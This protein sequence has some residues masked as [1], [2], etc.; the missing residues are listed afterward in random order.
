M[1]TETGQAV[2]ALWSQPLARWDAVRVRQA[3]VFLA[4]QA[5]AALLGLLLA[6]SDFAG[7]AFAAAAPFAIA[8][9]AAAHVKYLGM[10]ILGMAAGCLLLLDWPGNITAMAA[11]A[12]AGLGNLGLRRLGAR[13]SVAVPLNAFGCALA[14]AVVA[15]LAEPPAALIPWIF[16]ICGAVLAGC[17]G[18]FIVA[19]Q[20]VRRQ[21]GQL[22]VGRRECAALLL[23]GGM[24]LAALG[25]FSLGMFRPANVLGVLFV[26]AAA[27]CWREPGG[28]VAGVCAGAAL[29]LAGGDASLTA[30]FAFGGLLAGAFSLHRTRQEEPG[31]SNAMLTMPVAGGF[32]LVCVFFVML[33]GTAQHDPSSAVVFAI[34]S[35]VAIMAF[36]LVPAKLW[37]RLRAKLAAPGEE[38]SSGGDG[39]AG[40]RLSRASGALR[41]VGEFVG[42]VAQ[43]LEKIQTPLEPRI[44]AAAE[45]ALCKGCVEYP[46]CYDDHA[47]ESR[48]F[49]QQAVKRLKQGSALQP[50]EFAALR[51]DC[52]LTLPCRHLEQFRGV[53]LR[54]FDMYAAQQ[55]NADANAHLRKAAAAQFDA[56]SELIDEVG[57]QLT[58]QR[59]FE[60]EAAQSAVQVLEDHGYKTKTVSCVRG[61]ENTARLT[62]CVVPERE[63]SSRRELTR[64]LR[65]ATGIAFDLPEQTSM[66]EQGVA[67]LT[68]SQQPMYRLRTGAVQMSSSGSGYCGDYFDCFND[69]QGR[70]VMIVSDGMG[71]GGRAAVDS[72]LATEIFSSLARGGLSFTGAMRIA[73]QALLL[74]SCEESLAT[75]DVAGV[76]LY[77]GQVEFCKAGG[78]VSFTRQRGRAMRLEMSALPAGILRSIKPAVHHTVLEAGDIVVLVSDG[79]ISGQES[80]LCEVLEDWDNDDMQA[81]AEE[82]AG[83]AVQ[84]RQ[85]G[86][87]DSREDDLTVV[88]GMLGRV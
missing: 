19:A 65:R 72:A 48:K 66:P 35:I 86:E 63:H 79:M 18:W 32:A 29:V 36:V 3:A 44:H 41:E 20:G 76:N 46:Y 6:R 43:G 8:L 55:R 53:L 1:M 85:A 58:R 67:L 39:E 75:I 24:L 12:I 9:A 31:L 10:A 47:V 2:R 30:V 71:T 73:N 23:C 69:G 54:S 68:F 7:G 51:R 25:G 52:G 62:A 87:S 56:V 83:R 13:R 42:E 49:Y 14:S 11:C 82:L 33:F 17:A 50:E 27:Y 78:A 21:G 26:L 37:N 74:K 59:A 22:C 77:T 38:L 4:Q 15:L 84:L 60:T 40:L 28:A 61:A 57:S 81:L 64:A 16:A 45:T 80:W 5:G 88:C 34:E 70:E